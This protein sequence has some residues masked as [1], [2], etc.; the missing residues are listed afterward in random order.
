MQSIL[1]EKLMAQAFKLAQV[2]DIYRT[3][4]HRFVDEYFKW[5][6]E[7]EKDL[8]PLRSPISI[9]LQSEKSSLISVLDGNMPNHV[10]EGKSVRKYLKVF[11][12]QSLERVSKEIYAKIESI[13]N[14]FE[15]LNEKL[16][17][18]IAVLASR[19]P[20]LYQRLQTNQ[21][22]AGMIWR[23]IGQTPDTIPMYNYLCAKLTA[24]DINYLLMDIVHKIISNNTNVN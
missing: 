24:T 16:C 18:T 22:D 12:A 4:N 11:A 17:H 19:E 8:A 21:M 10:Q 6:E 2:S 13:D 3:E 5:L 1:R 9:L 15:Q 7:A 20:G 23:M 14:T